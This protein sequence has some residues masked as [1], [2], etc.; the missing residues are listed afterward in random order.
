M[1]AWK[2]VKLSIRIDMY[3][4]ARSKFFVYLFRYFDICGIRSYGKDKCRGDLF[5]FEKKF[6]FIAVYTLNYTMKFTIWYY[7]RHLSMLPD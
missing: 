2:I 7:A 6:N 3:R 1:K 4:E 5:K